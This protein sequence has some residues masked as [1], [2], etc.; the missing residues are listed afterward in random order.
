MEE[1]RSIKKGMKEALG[2]PEGRRK[3]MKKVISVQ[4]AFSA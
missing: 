1:P 2:E 3:R 4:R